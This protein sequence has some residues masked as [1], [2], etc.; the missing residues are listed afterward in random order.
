MHLPTVGK[1]APRWP[2]ETPIQRW[3]SGDT[4]GQAQG[5]AREGWQGQGKGQRLGVEAETQMAGKREVLHREAAASTESHLVA[6]RG[7]VQ[8]QVA[9]QNW[10]PRVPSEQACST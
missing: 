6:S 9:C 5:A 3:F 4:R 7:Q 1:R 2:A 10:G 8:Q